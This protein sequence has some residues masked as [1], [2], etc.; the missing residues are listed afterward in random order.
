[1][2]GSN[3]KSG[4][5]VKVRLDN[6]NFDWL[7]QFASINGKLSLSAAMRMLISMARKQA[8]VESIQ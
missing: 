6:D 8:S 3:L 7:C 5:Q 1:M 2:T 4:N